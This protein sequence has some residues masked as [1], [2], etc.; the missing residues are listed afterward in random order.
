MVLTHVINEQVRAIVQRA[1]AE[2]VGPGD[3]TSQWTL[4]PEMQVRGCFLVKAQGVLAGL[5]VA[6]QVFRQVDER[7]AFQAHKK[8]GDA[9]SEGDIIATVKGP[10]AG[11]LTAERTALNFLQRMSGIA[12]LT[13]RYVEAVA[14]TKAVILD[15]RKTAPGLRLLDKWA[16]RLGGGQNHRLGL[17]DMVLIKDNHIAA[18]GGITQAVERV[19]QRN[20]PGLCPER[21][22]GLAVEVEVKSLAELEEALALGV[23]RIMLDNMGLDEMRRAVEVTAGRVPLE[24]SGNVTLENVAAI[25]ATGVDYISVGALTHSVKALDISLEVNHSKGRDTTWHV[26]SKEAITICHES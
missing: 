4:P 24:A 20:R 9:I 25:A 11:I 26:Q 7:I 3:V 10:A 17:Y 16:V 12:T 2:D 14:G 19:R 21:V 6:C 13:R 5:E 15:T 1:L 23:D 8:D 18:A 22:E